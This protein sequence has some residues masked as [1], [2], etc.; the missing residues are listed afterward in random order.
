MVLYTLL[1][2]LRRYNL[3][4]PVKTKTE[5]VAIIN[6]QNLSAVKNNVKTTMKLGRK[7][8][9]VKAKTPKLE[10]ENNATKSQTRWEDMLAE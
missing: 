10:P 6:H 9:Q 2:L 4:I 5:T 1:V 8:V 7:K 3:T